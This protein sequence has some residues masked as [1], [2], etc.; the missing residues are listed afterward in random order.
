MYPVQFNQT[1][2]MPSLGQTT[3][4][5][6]YGALPPSMGPNQSASSL[7]SL[8]LG[9]GALGVQSSSWGNAGGLSGIVMS[10]IQTIS[11]VVNGLLSLVG[12][13]VGRQDPGAIPMPGIEGFAKPTTVVPSGVGTTSGAGKDEG[14]FS[15]GSLLSG[16]YDFV[17]GLFGGG[18]GKEGGSS[19]LGTIGEVVKD[20]GVGKLGGLFGK[21]GGF[22]KG[23]F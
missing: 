11:Q 3:L 19:D 12:S 6:T 7:L 14:G 20:F 15:I 21:I 23:L 5:N 22:I 2:S 17:T 1:P 16:A 4:N 8:G 13:L 18:Q 9:Q 10:L